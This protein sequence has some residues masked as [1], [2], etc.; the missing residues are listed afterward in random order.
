VPLLMMHVNN[1]P[2]PPQQRNPHVPA[3]LNAIILK[4]LAK[5]PKQRYQSCRD[6]AQ[7]LGKIRDAYA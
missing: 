3:E 1:Q 2:V 6:L 7:D 5:D 4:L